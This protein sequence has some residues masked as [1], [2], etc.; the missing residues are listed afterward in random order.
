MS[1]WICG[2]ALVTTRIDVA[3]NFQLLQLFV[4][5]N[6]IAVGGLCSEVLRMLRTP[7][8]RASVRDDQCINT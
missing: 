1:S 5:W 6:M 7:W 8:E 3:R 2:T 4:F